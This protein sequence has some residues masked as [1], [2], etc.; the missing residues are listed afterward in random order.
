VHPAN[1]P[2]PQDAKPEGGLLRT[3]LYFVLY[4]A[5]I[6]GALLYLRW[7]LPRHGDGDTALG[8]PPRGPQDDLDGKPD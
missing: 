1:L 4:A 5:L 2:N 7:K 8:S 6:L 3:I